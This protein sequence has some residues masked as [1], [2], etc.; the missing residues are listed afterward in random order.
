[1]GEG[2]DAAAEQR[3]DG[4]TTPW[5]ASAGLLPQGVR[6]Y[7]IGDIHGRADLLRDL[8]LDIIDDLGR[9]RARFPI[10]VFL[11]DYIDRGPA[12]AEVIELILKASET[13]LTVCLS[14]NHELY[15]LRFLAEPA[16][17]ASWFEVG[18][19]E[20]LAS[21][22]VSLPWRLTSRAL[23]AASSEFAELLPADHY[24]FLANLGLTASFGD[25][26]F[27]HAGI[28]PERPV[29]EQGESVLTLIREPFLDY[30]NMFGRIVVHGHTPVP[31]PDIRPNRINIDTGAYLTGRLTCLVIERGR[32]RPLRPV[33]DL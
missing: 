2:A 15:A 23:E 4:E 21:Y 28:Q 31:A 30:Q 33:A 26:L 32:L 14:G 25:Y 8:L 22:G 19:R 20:T 27:V 13:L 29:A 1:M 6:I 9:D 18:G 7:A 10:V 5:Q 17:G 11:G 12:S 3:Q 16:T 24:H